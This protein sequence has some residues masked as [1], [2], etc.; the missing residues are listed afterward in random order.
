MDKQTFLQ[1]AAER[2]TEYAPND[3]VQRQLN[4]LRMVVAVGPTGAGK[5]SIIDRS[6]IPHVLVDVTRAPRGEE[7]DGVDYHFRT[8]Y[9]Q[10][11]KEIDNGEVVQYIIHPNGEFYGTKASSYPTHGA[12]AL[13]IL[14]SAVPYF[15]RLGFG[16]LV[17]VFIVPPD[18]DE[19]MR[20][21]NTHS[22]ADREARLEEAKISFEYALSDPHCLLLLNDR[23]ATASQE[24]RAIGHGAG[25]VA[26]QPEAKKTIESLLLRLTAELST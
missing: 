6:G 16:T 1:A 24:F 10:L 4:G 11:L 5:T 3:D 12:C 21:V 13:A 14:S 7:E 20:R 23:L 19:W 18:Y 26:E 22:D 17:V 15:K 25:M 2:M 9:E 8:D